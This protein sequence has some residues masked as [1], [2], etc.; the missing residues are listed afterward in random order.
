M[1]H[2]I[3]RIYL[4]LIGL[5]AFAAAGMAHAQTLTITNGLTLWLKADAITGL[6]NGQAVSAWNDSSTN[7]YNATQTNETRQP[8]YV[9]NGVAGKPVVNFAGDI[10]ETPSIGALANLSV[11][12][13]ARSADLGNR[14]ALQFGSDTRAV[15][16]GFGPSDW[17]W[18]NTPATVTLQPMST[19]IFQTIWTTNGAS[20][21]GA[22]RVGADADVTAP[23]AGSI[24]EVLV[25]DHV[26]APSEVVT[27]GGYFEQKYGVEAIP[28]PTTMSLLGFGAAIVLRRIFSA[29]KRISDRIGG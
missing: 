21:A 27:V 8:V 28:E 1:N 29:R 19:T 5:A 16:Q 24:A 13:V 20:S 22:W 2:H 3:Q 7:G 17:R 15:I 14:Y 4:L 11:F 10:L 9:T 12:M 6:T 23:F 25:Y 26:L 18:F